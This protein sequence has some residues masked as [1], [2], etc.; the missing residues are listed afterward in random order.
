[1]TLTSLLLGWDWCWEIGWNIIDL[2]KAWGLFSGEPQRMTCHFIMPVSD[3]VE[4]NPGQVVCVVCTRTLTCPCPC[5]NSSYP[6]NT[7]QQLA[8]CWAPRERGLTAPQTVSTCHSDKRATD[9]FEL[10]RNNRKKHM[11][12]IFH[13]AFEC[14]L[15]SFLY[16]KG[17]LLKISWLE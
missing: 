7:A 13:C 9:I 6:Q 17:K 12:L 1:M 15:F 14:N 16:F 11:L 4:P 3:S 5:L 8:D 10:H 2:C